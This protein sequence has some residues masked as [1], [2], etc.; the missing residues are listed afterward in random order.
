MLS[1]CLCCFKGKWESQG[2]WR[3]LEERSLPPGVQCSEGGVVASP[4]YIHT[5]EEGKGFPVSVV[6]SFLALRVSSELYHGEGAG[7]CNLFTRT[8][9]SLFYSPRAK[10]IPS[11]SIASFLTGCKSFCVV[12]CPKSPCTLI[13]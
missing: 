7:L 11:P 10:E 6:P 4:K 5:P 1:G 9:T 2:S 3:A 12:L 13:F 8:R